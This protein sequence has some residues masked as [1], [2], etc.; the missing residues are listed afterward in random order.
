MIEQ[1]DPKRLFNLRDASGLSAQN[2]LTPAAIVQLLE[3]A[4]SAPWSAQF[5][6]ALAAP[7][8]EESTLEERLLPL[9][10]RLFAKTGTISNVNALSGYLVTDSGRELVFSILTN[11]TGLPSSRVRAAMDS[12]LTTIAREV[13]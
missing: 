10:G 13:R 12:V 3:H 1:R 6:A 4:R 9:Q 7:G 2:L 5:R 8:M 11:G